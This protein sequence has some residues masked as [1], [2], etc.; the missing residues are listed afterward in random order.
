MASTLARI[1]ICFL[2]YLRWSSADDPCPFKSTCT[3]VKDAQAPSDPT[4]FQSAV[5]TNVDPSTTFDAPTGGGKYKIKEVF[6][7][8][9]DVSK[10]A[11][12]RFASF[13]SIGELYL[14]QTTGTIP[15]SR[16]WYSTAFNN[17]RLTS[18]R[19][20]G[21]GD[22]AQVMDKLPN[23]LERLSISKSSALRLTDKTFQS[24]LVLKGLEFRA[25]K[26]DVDDTAFVGVSPSFQE[27]TLA[28][29]MLQA[30]PTNALKSLPKLQKLTLSS[31]PISQV[32]AGS[33]DLLTSLTL[34]DLSDTAVSTVDLAIVPKT[35]EPL[36]FSLDKCKSL[37]SI[38]LSI[39]PSAVSTHSSPALVP[40]YLVTSPF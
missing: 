4:A 30:V 3:C 7:L 23:T 13:E 20:D 38:T 40:R 39:D 32:A 17:I 11:D 16:Q 9:G 8:S 35:T 19:L 12:T 29:A 18:L 14:E 28:D 37:K 26:V 31:N 5:C 36:S 2:L 33:F 24:Y 1:A 10:F 15:V 27:L 34:L 25:T 6:R 21:L 22:L